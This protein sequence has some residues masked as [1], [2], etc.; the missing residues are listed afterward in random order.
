ML[1]LV[2]SNYVT[3]KAK[4]GKDIANDVARALVGDSSVVPLCRTGLIPGGAFIL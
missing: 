3:S 1:F 4:K 2:T